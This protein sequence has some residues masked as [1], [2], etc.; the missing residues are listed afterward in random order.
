PVQTSTS[1]LPEGIR[2]EPL[3]RL[4]WPTQVPTR[5][6]LAADIEFPLHPDRNW[7]LVRVQYV[8]TGVVDRSA[9]R[10]SRVAI[11]HR[12]N[13]RPD[14]CLGRTVQTPERRRSRQQFRG[15]VR[16]KRFSA[17]ENLYL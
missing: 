17:T 11:R 5:H 2:D 13:K 1:Q 6:S 14:R 4:P 7:L 16:R 15:E 10:Y 12:M 8:Y 3:S 9:E